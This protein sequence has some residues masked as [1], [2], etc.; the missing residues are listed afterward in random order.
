MYLATKPFVD[1]THTSRT[2]VHRTHAGKQSIQ[3][4][5]YLEKEKSYLDEH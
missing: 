5:W 3:S 2:V 4:L 1:G